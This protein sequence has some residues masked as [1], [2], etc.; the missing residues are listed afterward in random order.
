MKTLD[1]LNCVLGNT[2][3]TAALWKVLS[4]HAYSYFGLALNFDEI[5]RGSFLIALAHHCRLELEW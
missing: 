5:N 4:T 2:Y 1:F 3:E